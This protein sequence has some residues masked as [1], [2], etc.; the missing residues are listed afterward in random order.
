MEVK[1]LPNFHQLGLT[2]GS[3]VIFVGDRRK[4]CNFHLVTSIGQGPTKDKMKLMK[5]SLL[6][7]VLTY[8]S[9]ARSSAVSC[10]V[11]VY[12]PIQVAEDGTQV[13]HS[14]AGR[15]PL[16]CAALPSQEA[17][18]SQNGLHLQARAERD[19]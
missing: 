6:S 17:G 12:I 5:K 11:V 16:S 10:S 15:L 14:D 7:W 3:Y 19:W 1:T 4:L 8:L 13:P 18:G 9:S 2:D